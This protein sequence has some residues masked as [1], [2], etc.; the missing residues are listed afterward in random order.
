VRNGFR[1]LADAR[2]LSG[3]VYLNFPMTEQNEL[4]YEG[5]VYLE[6]QRSSA[7][8]AAPASPAAIGYRFGFIAL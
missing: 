6:R 2:L 8:T 3:G 4:V 7:R 5:T 1:N